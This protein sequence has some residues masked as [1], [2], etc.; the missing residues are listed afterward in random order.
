VVFAYLTDLIES[1]G[2]CCFLDDLGRHGHPG[3]RGHHVWAQAAGE[4][5]RGRGWRVVIA[6]GPR[7]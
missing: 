4:A 1:G 3:R 7:R 6:E 2:R 5:L